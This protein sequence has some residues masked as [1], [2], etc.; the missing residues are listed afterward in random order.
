[1]YRHLPTLLGESG[2][3]KLN[4]VLDLGIFFIGI[5]RNL[6]RLNSMT[7]ISALCHGFLIAVYRP[8]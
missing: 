6:P 8:S 2:S 7:Q 3:Y 4:M 1:M 5:I